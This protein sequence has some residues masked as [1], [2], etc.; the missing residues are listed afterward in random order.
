MNVKMK[1]NV[2][3]TTSSISGSDFAIECAD[4]LFMMNSRTVFSDDSIESDQSSMK[5]AADLLLFSVDSMCQVVAFV[6]ETTY[7]IL[8]FAI[9]VGT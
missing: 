9:S 2:L 1:G 8:E 6:S 7:R 4:D 5:L 3:R